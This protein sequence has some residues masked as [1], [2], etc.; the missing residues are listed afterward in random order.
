MTNTDDYRQYASECLRQAEADV[1][2]ETKNLLLTL[3]L[4]WIRLAR[5]TQEAQDDSWHRAPWRVELPPTDRERVGLVPRM[6][7]PPRQWTQPSREQ[8]ADRLPFDWF[9]R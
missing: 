4:A 5:Q 3:A 8:Q 1:V 7:E 6:P 2:P 9:Y